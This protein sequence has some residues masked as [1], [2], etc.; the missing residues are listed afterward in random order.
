V[1]DDSLFDEL[2]WFE[3]TNQR[4]QKMIQEIKNLDRETVM[5]TGLDE[6]CD[7]F[8]RK[9]RAASLQVDFD[10]IE[11]SDAEVDV[12]LSRRSRGLGFAYGFS[13][14]H[15]EGAFIKKGTRF[16]FHLGFSGDAELFKVQP[17]SYSSHEPIGSIKNGE[18]VF[19]VT[20]LEHNQATLKKEKESNITAL[21]EWLG[22]QQRDVEK[23]N[24]TVRPTARRLI[25]ERQ[26]KGRRDQA[27]VQSLG[28]PIRRRDGVSATYPIVAV[29]KQIA[30][31][32]PSGERSQRPAEPALE[33]KQYDEI[34]ATIQSMAMVMERSPRAFV[35]MDEETL[36]FLFL[37]PL[38]GIFEGQASG[39]LFNF[40][41]KTD[42]LIRAQD[43]N[44]FI[45]E[46]KFWKGPD[47]LTKTIDQLLGYTCWRDSKT[48]ILVFNRDRNF[49]TVLQK[50]P[51]A[52]QSHPNFVR[53]IPYSSETGWRFVFH[54]RDDK[55]RELSLTVLAF[56]VPSSDS[57]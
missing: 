56:E 32:R 31:P 53:V 28:V 3:W 50:I 30:L 44:V 2:R 15:D 37:V 9:Y 48:A 16:S 26:E 8:E 18:F 41:G 13:D 57:V 33:L 49:S 11:M 21:R 35:K 27:L 20:M 7:Y 42:I 12:N 4:E 36:R 10:N 47:G 45:A 29:K 6:W 43:K 19:S 25:E 34:L 24:E 38:N 40:E 51:G 39:E 22:V 14:D 46:C 23:F 17:S 52:I 55:A 54:H 5:S 1:N